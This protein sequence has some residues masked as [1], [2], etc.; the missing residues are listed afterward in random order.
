MR[1]ERGKH[2]HPR[3]CELCCLGERQVRRAVNVLREQ[4]DLAGPHPFSN[5]FHPPAQAHDLVCGDGEAHRRAAIDRLDEEVRA[6]RHVKLSGCRVPLN[7]G[8]PDHVVDVRRDALG[9]A[10]TEAREALESQVGDICEQT[11][12][13]EQTHWNS[14]D[15]IQLPRDVRENSHHLRVI[16]AVVQPNS[17]VRPG[18]VSRPHGVQR[19]QGGVD[20]SDERD[21][22]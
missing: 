15:L 12:R 21:P 8:A 13:Q 6:P 19:G 18:D 3:L 5:R 16:A 1:G 4:H 2:R 11:E 7:R 22:S 9:V 10:R 17:V 14:D 20:I